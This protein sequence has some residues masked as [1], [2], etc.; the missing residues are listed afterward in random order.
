MH[1]PLNAANTR[2]ELLNP[3]ASSFT[4]GDVKTTLK[5]TAD[6]GWVMMNDGT[7]GDASSGGTTRANADTQA[8]F[9]LLDECL[10]RQLSRLQRSRRLGRRRFRG[11]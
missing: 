1:D 10:E 6:A 7:I 11:A 3:V 8:L 9:G 2:W 5:T 4:T